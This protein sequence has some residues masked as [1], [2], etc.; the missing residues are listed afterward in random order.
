[1]EYHLT[2]LKDVFDK[3]P[4]DRIAA[5]LDELAVAM[6][7]TKAMAELLATTATVVA[8]EEVGCAVEWPETTTWIDDGKGT[9]DLKF[10]SEEGDDLFDYTVR[11][12]TENEGSNAEIT[13]RT[14]A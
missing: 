7:Q 8:G 9:L 6:R 10:Q 1:M 3:V 14:K 13:G 2:T 11:L 4:A 12:T 5:C